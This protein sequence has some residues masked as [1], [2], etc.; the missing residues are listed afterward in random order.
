[1]DGLKHSDAAAAMMEHYPAVRD[2]VKSEEFTEGPRAFAEK[3]LP[4]WKGR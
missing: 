3:R 1:M 4:V 2:M